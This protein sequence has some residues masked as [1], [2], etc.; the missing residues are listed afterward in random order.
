MKA[1]HDHLHFIGNRYD[2]HRLQLSG[3]RTYVNLQQRCAPSPF[4]DGNDTLSDP[5]DRRHL[6]TP[7]TR[8]GFVIYSNVQA[9]FGPT[10]SEKMCTLHSSRFSKQN[11]SLPFCMAVV[12]WETCLLSSWW[13]CQAHWPLVWSVFFSAIVL[14]IFFSWYPMSTP[15]GCDATYHCKFEC[16]ALFGWN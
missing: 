16:K 3:K 9:I 2:T 8:F 11:W 6:P 5:C 12:S 13:S 7:W 14:C 1:T 10:L 4:W 15:N